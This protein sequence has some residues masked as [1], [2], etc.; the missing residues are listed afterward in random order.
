MLPSSVCLPALLVTPLFMHALLT[1]VFMHRT[2]VLSSHF[3]INDL[4]LSLARAR[5]LSLFLFLF[6]FL[7]LL[8]RLRLLLSPHPSAR[9]DTLLFPVILMLACTRYYGTAR[10]FQAKGNA[11]LK[12][13]K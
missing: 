12:H 7:F 13:L 4:Y 11:L 9:D 5:S 6:L 10:N 8:L 2:Y 1:I 3:Y